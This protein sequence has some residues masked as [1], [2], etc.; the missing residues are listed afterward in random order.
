MKKKYWI[1]LGAIIVIIAIGFRIHGI[2]AA[3]PSQ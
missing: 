3:V 1:I 2:N